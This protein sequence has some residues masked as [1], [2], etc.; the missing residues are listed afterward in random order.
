MWLTDKCWKHG[1]EDCAVC[2]ML[3]HIT[4]TLEQRTKLIHSYKRVIVWSLFLDLQN[5]V[6]TVMGKTKEKPF[7][8]A[9]IIIPHFY[10]GIMILCL[11]C[12]SFQFHYAM[13]SIHSFHWY[14]N[15][16]G[17]YTLIENVS[18][19]LSNITETYNSVFFF[20]NSLKCSECNTSTNLFTITI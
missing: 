17:F 10:G 2:K 8:H 3:L 5:S 6:L 16:I 18:S 7:V 19:S 13:G 4:L 20:Y 1:K 14:H 12:Y 9:E 11:H 15:Q